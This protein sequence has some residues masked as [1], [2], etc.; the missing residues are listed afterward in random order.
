[1]KLNG[2][3][4][5]VRP[6][7]ST[8]AESLSRHA[9]NHAVWAKLR[10][11]F[12]HPY[13]LQ[14]ALEWIR[15]CECNVGFPTNLAI[16]FEGAAIGCIGIEERDDIERL[17]AEVGYWIGEEHWGKG[18][19][20]DALRVFVPYAFDHFG[21]LRLYAHVFAN[22]PASRRVLEKNGFQLEGIMRK[23][24][25]KQGQLLDE[26]LYSLLSDD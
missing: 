17:S 25:I 5:I 16:E 8:D 10:D 20:T 23:A 11:R 1:M 15:H 18:I 7:K 26:Y 9:T 13:T 3:I 4:C 24:V 6:M 2:S 22:N 21:I 14:D 12:P 19:A